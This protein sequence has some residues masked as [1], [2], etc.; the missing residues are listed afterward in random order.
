LADSRGRLLYVVNELYFFWSHRKALALAAQAAGYEIHVAAPATHA[1][2]PADFNVQALVDLGFAVHAIPLNRRGRNPLEE[3]RTVLAL[4]SLCRRLRPHV[5]HLLTIK[6]VLYGGLVARASGVPVVIAAVTGLGHA[7]VERGA[8][9]SV[10]RRL[11]A[12]LY[13]TALHQPRAQVIVQNEEDGERVRAMAGLRHEAV[14]LVRGSGVDL[15][16][17]PVGPEPEGA[18]LVVLPSRLIWEKGIAEFVAAGERLRATGARFALVG[19]TVAGYPRAVPE[20]DLRRWHAAGEVEWWG[21]RGDMPAVLAAA[22]I[23]CL[24][25]RYGEGVPRVLIEA[26]AAGRPTVATDIPG[27]RDIVR[28]GVNGILVPPGDVPALTSALERLID[29]PELR[30]RMGAAGRRMVEERFSLDLVI[31]QTLAIYTKA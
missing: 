9:A 1:W 3:L 26:A 20:A 4:W 19:G 29:D 5:V 8:R 30:R 23:V 10:M 11:L 15:A 12:L 14:H 18:P 25:S 27:C 6:P 13:R 2:A 16:E 24:P 31:A 7:F 22:A 17:F 28:D 21:R